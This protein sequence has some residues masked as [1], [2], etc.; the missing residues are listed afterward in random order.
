MRLAQYSCVHHSTSRLRV[1][2]PTAPPSASNSD[3]AMDGAG[4]A[5]R[6]PSPFVSEAS[7]L[8]RE[9]ACA[10]SSSPRLRSVRA[11]RSRL[12]R[13][14]VPNLDQTWP[15][16]ET[17]LLTWNIRQISFYRRAAAS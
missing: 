15:G 5:A 6:E 4:E 17:C 13:L 16:R 8:V 12:S 2:R 1:S 7:T 9:R 11:A 10:P 14:P 3:G